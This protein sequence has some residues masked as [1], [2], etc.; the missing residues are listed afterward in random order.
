MLLRTPGNLHGHIKIIGNSQFFSSLSFYRYV[1][2]TP[3]LVAELNLCNFTLGTTTRPKKT[4]LAVLFAFFHC[5]LHKRPCCFHQFRLF[6][7]HMNLYKNSSILGLKRSINQVCKCN[8]CYHTPPHPTHHPVQVQQM[9]SPPTPPRHP[10]CHTVQ[11]TKLP[12]VFNNAGS[13]NIKE[14]KEQ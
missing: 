8:G 14:R 7:L 3:K 12:G 4:S 6:R 2:N 9:L 13:I 11:K 5:C 10:T 1:K